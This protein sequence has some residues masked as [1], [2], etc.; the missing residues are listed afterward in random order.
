LPLFIWLWSMGEAIIVWDVNI[1]SI[2]L[3]DHRFVWKTWNDKKFTLSKSEQDEPDAK[4]T[5]TYFAKIK[6]SVISRKIVHQPETIS[7]YHPI[8]DHYKVLGGR[9]SEEA[10][11]ICTLQPSTNKTT[12][13]S[14]VAEAKHFVSRVA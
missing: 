5:K 11:I 2:L 13:T 14:T 12:H 10:Y 6:N 8:S 7:I 3:I 4:I 1:I 9:W